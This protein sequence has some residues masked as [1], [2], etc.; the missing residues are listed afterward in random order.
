MHSHLKGVTK[1]WCKCKNTPL[2]S[3]NRNFYSI[4]GLGIKC[5]PKCGGCNCGK[6]NPRGTNMILK[7]E[8]EYHLIKIWHI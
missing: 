1:K 7:E 8:I 6:Y 4:E 5:N 3:Q 2:I